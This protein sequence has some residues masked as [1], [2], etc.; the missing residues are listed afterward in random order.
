MAWITP[1]TDWVGTDTFNASDWLRIVGNVKY[2]ADSLS[3]AYTPFTSV[4][5]GQT[6]LTSKN[7]NDV[8]DMIEKLYAALYSSW[9]RGY[10][11]PRVDYGSTWNSRDLNAIE[12]LLQDMKKQIDGE[13]SS[14][15]DYYSGD[16]IYCRWGSDISIGLL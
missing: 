13:L 15:V 4:T 1:K 7:R 8:T 16:E 10:V 12:T 11:V 14:K 9:N 5:D 6:L 2:I 3:I